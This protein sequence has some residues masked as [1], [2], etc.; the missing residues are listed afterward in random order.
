MNEVGVDPGIDHLLAMEVFDEIKENGGKV[1]KSSLFY[2]I[3]FE[4]FFHRSAFLV[5]AP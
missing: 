1:R 2:G 5:E 4:L 3:Q